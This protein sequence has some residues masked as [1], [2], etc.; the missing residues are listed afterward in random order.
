MVLVH[1]QYEVFFIDKVIAGFEVWVGLDR[2]RLFY[3]DN[4]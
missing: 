4:L 3:Q 2:Q 1:L